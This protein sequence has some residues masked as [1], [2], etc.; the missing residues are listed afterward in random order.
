M[1][2]GGDCSLTRSELCLSDFA[3]VFVGQQPVVEA[4]RIALDAARNDGG[5]FPHALFV[6]PPGLGKSNLVQIIAREM[7]VELRETLAQTLVQSS[8]LAGLL[9]D[10]E[11]RQ[12][13]FIDEADEMQP[14]QQTL[15]YRAL[16]EAKLF[17]PR[18]DHR[19]HRS[20]CRWPTRF[21]FGV[22]QSDLNSRR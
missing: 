21:W 15:L 4:V 11:S 13:L 12:I 19:M 14:E 7:G 6:G 8:D 1:C 17:L 2:Y 9:L 5:R 3:Q 18:G 22:N 20:A 10:T 16:A